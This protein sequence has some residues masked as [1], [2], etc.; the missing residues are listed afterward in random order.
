MK[1]NRVF[2]IALIISIILHIATFL[3]FSFLFTKVDDKINEDKKVKLAFKR[4]GDIAKSDS[5]LKEN[6]PITKPPL[7]PIQSQPAQNPQPMPA[8]N[9]NLKQEN[10]KP[11]DSQEIKEQTL[12]R[13]YDLSKLEVFDKNIH[14]SIQQSQRAN[15]I[16]AD[17]ARKLQNIPQET[18]NEIM[19]LY[20]DELGDYGEA[21]QD[22]IINNLRDI[23]RITQYY[24]SKRGYPPDAG[25]LGQQGTN[26]VEFYLY[27]NGDI[28]D[29]KIIQDSRSMI[30]DKNT[31]TIIQIAYKDYPHPTTKTKIRIFVKY[32]IW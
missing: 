19:Q 3:F 16:Q 32:Y 9:K 17:I 25:Y 2:L 1:R 29:L 11:K 20:G 6:T 13:S 31:M 14:S 12:P 23:G 7:P 8:E 4:G 30:L 26:A 15:S 28:S 21:E 27:P 22:F 5:T 24:L 18:Q 10:S